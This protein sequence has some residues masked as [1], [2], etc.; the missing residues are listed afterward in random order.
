M[1]IRQLVIRFRYALA[2]HKAGKR[3]ARRH[4]QQLLA[5][6]EHVVDTV[7]PR[8]RG[9]PGYRKKLKPCV[10]RSLAY[11]CRIVDF[12]PGPT[13][14]NSK[15]WS[16]DP[17]LRAM[18]SSV[19]DLHNLYSN[20]EI[21]DFFEHNPG[22]DVCYTLLSSICIERSVLGMEMHGDVVKRDVKQTSVSFT[23]R[24][25]V[26]SA[27]SEHALREDLRQR[28]LDGIVSV[29][30]ERI[31]E[32]VASRQAREEEKQLLNMRRRLKI[33]KDASLDPLLEEHHSESA[34]LDGAVTDRQQTADEAKHPAGK[35]DA[36]D[37]YIDRIADVLDHPE[38]HLRHKQISMR[39]NRM[40]VKL[41][42]DSGEAGDNLELAEFLLGQ[43]IK[44]ILLITRFPRSE[45]QE[46]KDFRL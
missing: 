41:G 14:A 37:D 35:L 32:L 18:F 40:N 24:R 6:I 17:V 26:K 34:G 9:I 27:L 23:D 45:M 46:V 44:R 25:T 30:L 3:S 13:D 15:S 43:H 19:Q 28:A 1:T 4:E 42:E 11:C 20:R 12:V 10:S 39:L 29:A 22:A 8:L 31:T 5:A 2:R 21:R 38:A 36:L 33:V 7:N 16:A